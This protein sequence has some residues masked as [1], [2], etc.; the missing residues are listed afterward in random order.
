M[1]AI[2]QDIVSNIS[3]LIQ[4]KMAQLSSEQKYPGADP[5]AMDDKIKILNNQIQYL[6]DIRTSFEV[7]MT[8]VILKPYKE[9]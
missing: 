6:I 8:D 7:M 9:D 5:D 4:N 3:V 2:Q 1:K